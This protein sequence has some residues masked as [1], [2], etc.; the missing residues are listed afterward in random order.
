MTDKRLPIN[1]PL[2]AII[3]LACLAAALVL[4]IAWPEQGLWYGSFLRVGVVMA[5]FW[6]ALPARGREAAWARISPWAL[7]GII[8]AIMLLPRFKHIVIPLVVVIALAAIFLRPRK[9]VRPP[10]AR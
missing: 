10:D 5:V 1:R 6:L 2:V 3:A 8:V 4:W 7:G 9:R